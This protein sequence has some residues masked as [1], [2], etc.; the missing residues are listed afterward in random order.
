MGLVGIWL[1]CVCFER[2]ARTLFISASRDERLSAAQLC[3]RFVDAPVAAASGPAEAVP[4]L[5]VPAYLRERRIL[6]L[7]ISTFARD[8]AQKYANWTFRPNVRYAPQ[9]YSS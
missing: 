1:G 8:P 7:R 4:G 9:T 2:D 3:G 6:A 5:A